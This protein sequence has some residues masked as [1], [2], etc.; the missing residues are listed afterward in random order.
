MVR[1][2]LLVSF[3]LLLAA[4]HSSPGIK[5]SAEPLVAS[6]IVV[7]SQ[8]CD[9]SSD[10]VTAT[11]SWVP[12]R[13]GE[14]WLDISLSNN[15][16]AA[17]TFV[18]AGPLPPEADS[19]VWSGLSPGATYFL[20]VNTRSPFGWE[21]SQTFAV[22]TASCASG[23][24]L[25]PAQLTVSAQECETSSPGKVNT[26]LSWVPSGRGEQWLDISLFNNHFA[27][28]TFIGVGPFPPGANVFVWSGL[29]PGMTHFVR[30]DTRSPFGW[31]PGQTMAFATP[32][33][34]GDPALPMPNGEFVGLRETLRAEIAASGINAA[35][36]VTDLQT[37]ES[38]DVNGEQPRLPGCT[39]NFFVL[40]SVVMDLQEGLY[41]ESEVGDLISRTVWS[42]NPVTAR[43]LLRKTGMG[44]IGAGLMKVNQL[45][46]L[47][48]LSTSTYD[49]PPAY[50]QE[51]LQ[52]SVNLLTA[53]DINRALTA[54]YEARIL[55]PAWRDYLLN[56]MMGVK[57]GLQYLIPAGVAGGVVAHKNGFFADYSG[58][59]D[60]DAGVVLFDRGGRRYA[61]AISFFTED[62]SYKYA[63]IPLGQ[64][65][66][67][68]VWQY[69]S[70]RYY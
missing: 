26:T 69:F 9:T 49:H 7:S 67:R 34:D 14:Q 32:P 1:R 52:G 58:W 48:G 65:V 21:P 17:D 33:C 62:V 15:G 18:G 25:V 44:D 19:F 61:Y 55:E 3:S 39:I 38:I 2:L 8:E 30:V 51:S 22:V 37:G 63:D 46:D 35:V 47:L 13:R 29:Q 36:A 40:L 50:P 59:V 28:G 53:N 10:G 23:R 56:K 27:P 11:V 6:Q 60:N 42:S 20:R 64:T 66:S 31:E 54:V 45:L 41:S 43:D 4:L 5:V 12:S 24:T 16:F 70:S 68:L 57:P